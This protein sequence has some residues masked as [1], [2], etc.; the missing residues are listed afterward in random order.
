MAKQVWLVGREVVKQDS[1]GPGMV[2]NSLTRKEEGRSVG[3]ESER[4]HHMILLA[5]LYPL[6]MD[7]AAEQH[8]VSIITLLLPLCSSLCKLHCFLPPAVLPG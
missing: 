4:L 2:V 7:G 3:L 8:T 1:L 5:W 6:R